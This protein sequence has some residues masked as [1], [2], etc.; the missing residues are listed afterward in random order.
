[1]EFQIKRSS[2][3][4][5]IK[6]FQEQIKLSI[7]MGILKRGDIL[8]SI[9]E[10]EK[11]T[12]INRGQIHRAFLAL[13]KSGLLAPAPRRRTAVA[14]SAAAPDSINKKCL[15]LTKD[16]IQRI[17]KIGV[18]P[19][20]YA[21]YLSQSAQED[22]RQ[23]PFIAYVDL[24][25]EVALRRA[26]QT[27]QL[28]QASVVGLSVE[29]FKLALAHRT[30]P[31]KILVNHLAY[32]NIEGICRGRKIDIIPIEI[33]HSVQTIRA[34]RKIRANSALLIVFSNKAVPVAPVV[35]EQLRKLIKSKDANLSWIVVN[36]VADFK[37]L[38]NSSSQYDRILVSPDAQNIVPVGY[39]R[40]S[41][42]LRF[43]MDFT[44]EGL[45]IA[46]IRSGVIV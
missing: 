13:R 40:N 21:R 29:E 41:R 19:I 39:R 1:M 10:V 31:R 17:R 26:K 3:I 46:R 45:E 15:E 42:I 4:P 22:E 35:V 43:Q 32:D 34:L 20:A 2:A 36:E 6:Q 16:I 8:P 23:F 27:S 37:Q 24:D 28:W 12:G 11:Q 14:I 9:R 25:K 5:I 44:P 30:G 38:L 7:S 18:S 33:C